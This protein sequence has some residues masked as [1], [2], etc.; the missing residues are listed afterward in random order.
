MLI[1]CARIC[2]LLRKQ[3]RDRACLQVDSRGSPEA[4]TLVHQ[5][6]PLVA[7]SL[8]TRDG[9]RMLRFTDDI[10]AR[11]IHINTP[12]TGN[13]PHLPVHHDTLLGFFTETSAVYI[14]YGTERGRL[15]DEGI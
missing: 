2:A 14:E 7:A 5:P 3:R 12:T 1:G 4:L 13:E 11:S 10:R 6:Q 9:A 8:Y 15:Q